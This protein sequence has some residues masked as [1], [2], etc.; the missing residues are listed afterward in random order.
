[1]HQAVL[2]RCNKD[3]NVDFRQ[4]AS[5][6]QFRALE[7]FVNNLDFMERRG[8]PMP[9]DVDAGERAHHKTAQ[10]K[11]EFMTHTN[12][13]FSRSAFKA[14]VLGTSVLAGLMLALP[15]QA[16]QQS[17]QAQVGIEEIIVTAQKRAQSLQD[18]PISLAVISGDVLAN[19][20]IKSFEEL[21]Q[22]VP[23]LFV[24]KTPGADQ[25]TMRGIGSGAG[26]PSLDQSVVMFIDGVYAGNSRQFTA[27]FLDIERMEI[28]RGPQGALVGK[29]TSAGAINIITKR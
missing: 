26:S 15:A 3:K 8:L 6:K 23:N 9:H 1:M 19:N 29:N 27:P 13:R 2:L 21:G 28:L 12:R 5:T 24:T 7:L 4:H 18:V 22:Y 16:Q 17:A 25:I 11:G 20:S 14:S 10:S